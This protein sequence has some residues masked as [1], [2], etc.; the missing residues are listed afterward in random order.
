[1]TWK[2]T[3]SYLKY[4]PAM[5]SLDHDRWSQGQYLNLEA[6]EYEQGC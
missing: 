4:Y 2:W 1:M 6:L 5:E 3:W